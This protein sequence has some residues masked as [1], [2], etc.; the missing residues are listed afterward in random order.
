MVLIDIGKFPYFYGQYG[1]QILFIQKKEMN[2]SVH[3]P[4]YFPWLGLLSKVEKSNFLIVL[5]DAQLSD[6][7]FQHR[8]Q[9]L[10]NNGKVKYLTIPLVKQN[11]MTKPFKDL[12]IADASWGR[13]HNNFIQNSYKTHPYFDQI[14]SAIRPVFEEE[15]SYL[16]DVVLKSMC[17][18]ME[19]CEIHV[20]LIMQSQVDYNREAARGELVVELLKATN[21]KHYLSGRGAEAY[22]SDAM[23]ESAGITLKYM[24]FIHPEY[25]QKNS[26]EFTAGLSCLDLLFNVGTKKAGQLMK[27]ITL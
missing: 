8:N 18:S 25:S 22:Q 10:T 24:N 21:A 3:Q 14:Y 1:T 19:L 23:F 6:S 27:S 20:E 7:A 9:F 4:C 26:Q 11:Y 13:R 16:I 17:I 5:D 2:Y 12:K 15:T